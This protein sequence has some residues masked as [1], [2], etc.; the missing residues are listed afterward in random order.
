M[1]RNIG[2]RKIR[3]VLFGIL[4]TLVVLAPFCV[5]LAESKSS[6]GLGNNVTSQR[7]IGAAN[8]ANVLTGNNFNNF[9]NTNTKVIM[10]N[11]DDSYKTQ[12]LYAKPILDQ[13]GFK[14]TFFEVCGWV[15]K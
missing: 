2:L 3:V 7:N 8:S 13:Y 12:V 14:A 10:I 5:P 15:G 4:F 6:A 9:N 11:F 1:D